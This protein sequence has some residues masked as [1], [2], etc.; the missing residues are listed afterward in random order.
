MYGE[1]GGKEVRGPNDVQG[2]RDAGACLRRTILWGDPKFVVFWR[3]GKKR[4]DS[5][6]FWYRA[7]VQSVVIVVSVGIPSGSKEK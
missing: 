5:E 2:L 7:L 4:C 3:G 6:F 1:G